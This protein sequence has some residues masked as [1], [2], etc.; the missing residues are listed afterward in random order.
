MD[1]EADSGLLNVRRLF[2]VV[3]VCKVLT[4]GFYCFLWQ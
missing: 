2:G 3:L 4:G 1:G